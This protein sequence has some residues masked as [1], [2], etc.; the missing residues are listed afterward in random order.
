MDG[1]GNL[2]VSVVDYFVF[3]GGRITDMFDVRDK[4]NKQNIVEFISYEL[5]SY[6]FDMYFDNFSPVLLHLYKL[7]PNMVLDSLY[8]RDVYYSVGEDIFDTIAQ[9][10]R[11]RMKN[12]IM[13]VVPVTV[14]TDLILDFCKW[15]PRI[16]L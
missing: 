16:S 2:V 3:M 1:A 11:A 8:P 7:Y 6:G 5:L 12:D 9:Q 14:L 15:T 4:Y 13:F 10:T